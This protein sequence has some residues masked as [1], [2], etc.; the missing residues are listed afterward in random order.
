MALFERFTGRATDREVASTESTFLL[1]CAEAREPFDSNGNGSTAEKEERRGVLK[2]RNDPLV[3]SSLQIGSELCRPRA[4]RQ[5]DPGERHPNPPQEVHDGG[6]RAGVFPSFRPG[7]A[8]RRVRR[9]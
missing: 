8:A 5:R 6:H 1:A 3:R 2:L 4:R 9:D 7:F